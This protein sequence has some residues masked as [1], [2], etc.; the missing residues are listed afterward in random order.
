[1]KK[2]LL[3]VFLFGILYSSDHNQQFDLACK[4]VEKEDFDT[5]L[6]LFSD[7]D[8]RYPQNMQLLCNIGFVLKK[9][10]KLSQAINVYEKARALS[11]T[12]SSQIERAISHAYLA[13]GDLEH[14]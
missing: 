11:G 14:G 5:A 1:M 9:Q 6:A 13:M 7:L 3:N 2:I 8:A 12:V 10:H 4:A